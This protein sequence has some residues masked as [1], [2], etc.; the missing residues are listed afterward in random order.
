M[1][2]IDT[3]IL[4]RY[5]VKDDHKQTVI[6]TEFLKNN[7]C[8]IIKTVLLELAWVLSSEA[9]YNLSRNVGAERLRHICGLPTVTVEDACAVAQSITWY[10]QGMDFAD[11]LHLASSTYCSGF[12]TMDRRMTAKASRLATGYNIITL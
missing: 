8:Y 9:G 10:E 1:I 12:A 7:A 2:V 5:A 3:N 4:V 6:A 11:A